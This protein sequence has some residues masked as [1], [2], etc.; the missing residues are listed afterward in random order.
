MIVDSYPYSKLWDGPSHTRAK[1][2]WRWI[3]GRNH[4]IKV[5][6]GSKILPGMPNNKLFHAH[7]QS[8]TSITDPTDNSNGPPEKR[9][10]K[11]EFT[12]E[13][14]G[15]LRPPLPPPQWLALDLIVNIASSML[16]ARGASTGTYWVITTLSGA[17]WT[18]LLF[19]KLIIAWN[20][21]TK[22][23]III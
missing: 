1:L 16:A 8:K 18:D 23:W 7:C 17:F 5:G 20:W 11:L 4:G 22:H 21:D 14:R 13:V 3:Q 15:R 9:S 10:Q 12:H 2:L 19:E 6:R